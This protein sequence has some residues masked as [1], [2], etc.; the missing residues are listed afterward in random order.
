M[1][2]R[3]QRTEVRRGTFF[4]KKA[5]REPRSRNSYHLERSDQPSCNGHFF[6]LFCPFINLQ[7]FSVTVEAL[8]VIFIYMTETSVHPEGLV[9]HP[10]E[11]G[12]KRHLALITDWCRQAVGGGQQKHPKEIL[13]RP[14]RAK[15]IRDAERARAAWQCSFRIGVDSG[16]K[17]GYGDKQEKCSVLSTVTTVLP[18]SRRVKLHT[19]H[20]SGSAINYLDLF[21]GPK[22][23]KRQNRRI[24][25]DSAVCLGIVPAAANA[26]FSNLGAFLPDGWTDIR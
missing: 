23:S 24:C 5:S 13:P 8:D 22:R 25:P 18:G 21:K 4:A 14:G 2:V 20:F 6:R 11:K 12:L 7:D 9:A 3:L 19:E 10:H 1:P 17:C 16:A 15:G 26:T